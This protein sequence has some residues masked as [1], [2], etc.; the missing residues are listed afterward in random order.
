MSDSI[1]TAYAQYIAEQA[2]TQGKYR[3]REASNF[4]YEVDE[5]D[6][7]QSTTDDDCDNTQQPNYIVSVKSEENTQ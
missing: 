6:P 1:I 2:K 4:I 3:I 7:T 5:V